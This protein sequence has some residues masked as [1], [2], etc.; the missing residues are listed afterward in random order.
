MSWSH[1]YSQRSWI[2]E[3]RAFISA[4]TLFRFGVTAVYLFAIQNFT[5]I[6]GKVAA[7]LIKSENNENTECRADSLVYK[8]ILYIETNNICYLLTFHVGISVNITELQVFGVYFM[9]S[10]IG[11]FYHA[12]LHRNFRTLRQLLLQRLI[13]SEVKNALRLLTILA[14]SID[15]RMFFWFIHH[16]NR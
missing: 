2:S 10:Y 4:C 5:T 13:I 7:R 12:L 14:P 9:Q 16:W 15:H 6:G 8:V 11:V 3:I 1:V